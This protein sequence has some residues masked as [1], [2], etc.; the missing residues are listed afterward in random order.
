MALYNKVQKSIAKKAAAAK[1]K[2]GGKVAMNGPVSA[3]NDPSG[4][5]GPNDPAWQHLADLYKNGLPG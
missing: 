1:A 3:P 4:T 5:G 2:K